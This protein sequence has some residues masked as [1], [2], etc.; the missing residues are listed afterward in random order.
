MAAPDGTR[1]FL[2]LADYIGVDSA[3]KINALGAGFTITGLQATGMTGPVF[4][5]AVIDWPA[6]SVGSQ[7][8][9][10]IELQDDTTGQ[11][12][13]VPGPSG[14]FEALRIQQFVSV[15]RQS[16]LQGAAPLP[17]DLPCRSQVVVGFPAGLPLT[18][19][20]AYTWRLNIDG[21]RL[22]NWAAGFYVPTPPPLPTFGGPVGSAQIP[23]IEPILDQDDVDDG[24]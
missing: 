2:L 1:A 9:V 10:S 11:S 18:L 20:R 23:G 24:P 12:A 13:V 4:I 17:E 16:Q 15:E 7:F 5:A 6:S 19:G 21:T 14:G 8:P 3:G 22:R